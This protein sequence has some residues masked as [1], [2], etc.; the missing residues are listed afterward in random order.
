[1]NVGFRKIL[2]VDDDLMSAK[3]LGDILRFKYYD[4]CVV[5]SASAALHAL[6]I[7]E[8]YDGHHALFSPDCIISDV[9]M[10]GMNGVVLC[11]KVRE[12]FPDLSIMLMTAY[13]EKQL[14]Q[15]GL[16][17]GVLAVLTKP[18]DI[19]HLLTLLQGG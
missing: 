13:T 19:P 3:T 14:L 9:K 2:I 11:Q 10:P 6:G 4:V 8:M 1:M 12:Y 18:L 15:E 16:N 5:H 7:L 17:E